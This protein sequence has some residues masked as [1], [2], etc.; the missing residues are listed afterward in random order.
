[1]ASS[2]GE[3]KQAAQISSDRLAGRGCRVCACSN[4]LECLQLGLNSQIKPDSQIDR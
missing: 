1:M 3:D 2:G 4:R